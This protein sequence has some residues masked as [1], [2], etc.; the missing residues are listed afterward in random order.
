MNRRAGFT[1]IEVFVVLTIFS[2]VIMAVYGVSRGAIKIHQRTR[3]FDLRARGIVLGL[4]RLTENLREAAPL[5][6]I[7]SD[8]PEEFEFQ[9]R[10]NELSF[11][12]FGREGM[13]RLIYSFEP[14][15]GG[16]YKLR[17]TQQDVQEGDIEFERDL[18]SGIKKGPSYKFFQYLAYNRELEI[19]EWNDAWAGEDG[20]PKAVR[21][22]LSYAA[23]DGQEQ[24][25]DKRIFIWQ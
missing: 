3:E 11:V 5:S 21:V 19:Y 10:S 9:G 25:L 23:E 12:C 14:D 18:G 13:R 1:F 20:L 15:T 17:L 7:G 2:I 4:A 24:V 22:E 6:K 8:I 16:D